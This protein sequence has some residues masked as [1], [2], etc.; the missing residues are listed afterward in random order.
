MNRGLQHTPEETADWG[1]ALFRQPYARECTLI[2]GPVSICNDIE[3]LTDAQGFV[4]APFAPTQQEPV[5]VIHPEK[6]LR[7]LRPDTI[8]A[9]SIVVAL[10]ELPAPAEHT[11]AR[12]DYHA[13]FADFHAQLSS[14]SFQ[15]LV[16]ARSV[17]WPREEPVAKTMSGD[18][19]SAS[20]HLQLFQQACMRYPRMFVCLVFT[21]QSGLWLAATPETL[22]AG[23][24]DRWQTMALAGTMPWQ[25]NIAW[26]DKNLQEQRYVAT[27]ISR[28]LE[29]FTDDFAERGP[30]T[31]RAGHLAHLRSDF[32]FSLP[33]SASIG[34]LISMLHP[35]PAVCGLP[36]EEAIRFILGHEHGERSYYSGFMGPFGL[37][38]STHL[39]VTLRCM[40]IFSNAC[41]L[42]AGGGLLTDSVEEQEWQETEAKLDTMRR[43]LA[44]C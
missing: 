11:D 41:R 34:Q 32:L 25:E 31:T 22:L 6:M 1:F 9:N 44:G 16:L 14:G 23:E 19:R 17:V 30:Y 26:S 5:V 18:G 4:M 2:S 36:K 12:G 29:R 43:L 39:F 33:H 10:D 3:Q 42:Y 40:R 20:Q 8:D 38:G 27:Y 24:G 13:D 7:G 28:L 37:N 35:T 21:P 15:K